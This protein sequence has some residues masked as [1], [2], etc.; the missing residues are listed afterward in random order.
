VRAREVLE[1]ERRGREAQ[2]GIARVISSLAEV[3]G[4]EELRLETMHRK[5]GAWSKQE[6]S[7]G[8]PEIHTGGLRAR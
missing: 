1:G 3:N 2:G 5:S 8:G 6:D 4:F 7:E